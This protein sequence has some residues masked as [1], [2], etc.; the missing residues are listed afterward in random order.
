MRWLKKDIDFSFSSHP[1]SQVMNDEYK[2]INNLEEAC[3]KVNNWFNWAFILKNSNDDEV[4][5]HGEAFEMG[6]RRLYE[7]LTDRTYNSKIIIPN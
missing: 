2:N 3:S 5:S 6:A 4:R 1:A 7:D